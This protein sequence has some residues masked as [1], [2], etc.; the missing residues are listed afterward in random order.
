MILN[1]VLGIEILKHYYILDVIRTINKKQDVNLG[2]IVEHHMNVLCDSNFHYSLVLSLRR[3]LLAP[4]TTNLWTRLTCRPRLPLLYLGPL[5][6]TFFNQW[7]YSF[8]RNQ[9]LQV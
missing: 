3:R 7:Y 2:H 6:T 4:L 8:F 1:L 5:S 9:S